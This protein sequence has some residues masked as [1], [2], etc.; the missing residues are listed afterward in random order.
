MTTRTKRIVLS[1]Y[2]LLFGMTLFGIFFEQTGA[3][4][5]SVVQLGVLSYFYFELLSQNTHHSSPSK[6]QDIIHRSTRLRFRI[7]QILLFLLIGIDYL[8]FEQTDL[9]LVSA[10]SIS[11]AVPAII[12]YVRLRK[13]NH[14]KEENDV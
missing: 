13:N 10:F 9:L 8:F 4:F 7:I 14:L 5:F 11:I 2:L 12:R 3:T 6:E 1:L